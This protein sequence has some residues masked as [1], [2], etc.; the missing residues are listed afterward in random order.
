MWGGVGESI[1]FKSVLVCTDGRIVYAACSLDYAKIAFWL[2]VIFDG[3]WYTL[4]PEAFFFVMG[5]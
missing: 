5:L 1:S 2:K 4:E 3:G